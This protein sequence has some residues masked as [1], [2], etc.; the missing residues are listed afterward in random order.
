MDF[1][2]SLHRVKKDQT[3]KRDVVIGEGTHIGY[4]FAVVVRTYPVSLP[5]SFSASSAS[6]A[7]TQRFGFDDRQEALKC[8]EQKVAKSLADGYTLLP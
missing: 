8:A 1:P 6:S 2:Q 4:K 5:P 7:D 3:L